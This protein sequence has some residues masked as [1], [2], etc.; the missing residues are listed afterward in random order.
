[1]SEKF[2]VVW[3]SDSFFNVD[4]CPEVSDRL[5]EDSGFP[6]LGAANVS[7]AKDDGTPYILRCK[8]GSGHVEDE[9]TDLRKVKK[10]F[11]EEELAELKQLAED[12]R[13]KKIR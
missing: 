13:N 4:V 5:S 6:T 3:V 9:L 12:V 11:T 8:Y 7:V 10:L 1:M 2:K